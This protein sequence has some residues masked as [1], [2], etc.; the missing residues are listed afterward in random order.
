M[1]KAKHGSF[2]LRAVFTAACKNLFMAK[3]VITAAHKNMHVY[4]MAISFF[5][6]TTRLKKVIALMAGYFSKWI[7][8]ITNSF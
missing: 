4:D 6:E 5:L 1:L 7:C 2:I 8:K 3:E